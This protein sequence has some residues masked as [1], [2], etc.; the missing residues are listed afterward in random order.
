MQASLLINQIKDKK[1]QHP[2]R[3]SQYSSDVI[4]VSVQQKRDT[5]MHI[6][7]EKHT[8]KTDILTYTDL[9]VYKK[10]SYIP[11]V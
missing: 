6:S 9:L 11:I 4:S 8:N 5:H 2:Q 1:L 3:A 7:A 10:I